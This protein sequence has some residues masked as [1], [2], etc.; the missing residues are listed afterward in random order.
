MMHCRVAC[1]T[2]P[3]RIVLWM[4]L[5]ACCAATAMASPV[6]RGKVLSDVRCYMGER[7]K[8]VKGALSI[9]Y[10]SSAACD[11]APCYY[12][13]SGV[14]GGFVIVSGNDRAER[15]L[16]YSTT[17]SFRA[18]AL[19]DNLREWLQGYCDQMCALDASDTVSPASLQHVAPTTRP[20]Q[21]MVQSHWG[22]YEPFN[23]LCPAVPSGGHALSGCVAM[24]MAMVMRYY[25]Y[26][27]ATL[28]SIPVYV[29]E[30]MG[31]SPLM[32]PSVPAGTSFDWSSMLDNYR[33]GEEAR[34]QLAV[35][36]LSRVCGLS[37][38]TNYGASLSTAEMER[39]PTAL[40]SYFGYDGG[41]LYK[42]R[43]FFSNNEWM[44][45]L[46][47]ELAAGRPVIYKGD[48][49]SASHA[50]II[51][52]C[53]GDDF[54]HVNWGFGD[55][56]DGY[57]RLDALCH[58]DEGGRAITSRGYTIDHG[59]VVGIQ[60][61]TGTASPAALP[62]SVV[63]NRVS[64][65]SVDCTFRN[66]NN[67]RRTFFCALGYADASGNLHPVSNIVYAILDAGDSLDKSFVLGSLAPGHY[68]FVPICR[69]YPGNGCWVEA[70]HRPGYVECVVDSSGCAV[71]ALKPAPE[72]M[73]EMDF[74]A[75][76]LS[77]VDQP[78]D[79]T[80]HNVGGDYSGV[81]HL[82]AST[83][84]VKGEVADK[85]GVS[86]APGKSANVRMWFTPACKGVHRV[87]LCS[88][89]LGTEVVSTAT[90]DI[91]E[92]TIVSGP[93]LDVDI[94]LDNAGLDCVYGK[95][96]SGVVRLTNPSPDIWVGAPYV[97][98]FH[99]TTSS[100]SFTGDKWFRTEVT[101]AP[102]DSVDIP[103]EHEGVMG[104]Y[105]RV[106]MRYGLGERTVKSSPT[107]Q[108]M[109]G[110]ITWQ[111]DG[112]WRA[113]PASDDIVI[114]EGVLA[115]DFTGVSGGINSVTPN[116]NPNTLYYFSEGASIPLGLDAAF[117]NV[118]VGGRAASIRLEDGHSFHAPLSFVADEIC[119]SRVPELLTDGMGYWETIALP[120][121][122]EEVTLDGS[123]M[124][125]FRSADDY[126]KDFWVRCFSAY[127][128]K[129]LL[130]G[131]PERMEANVPYLVAF[132]GNKS[133]N[134]C[135]FT[136]KTVCFRGKDAF[137]NAGVPMVCGSEY[138]SFIGTTGRLSVGPAYVLNDTGKWFEYT[139]DA[140]VAP[141]RAYVRP[142]FD[143]PPMPYSLHI[144]SEEAMGVMAVEEAGEDTAPSYDLSGRRVEGSHRG[145]VVS[146][147]RKSLGRF[148]I[149]PSTR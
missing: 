133:D 76:R 125:F 117:H 48:T 31:V 102:G 123:P 68:H 59:M 35:A 84:D 94:L 58:T 49:K 5:A 128:G 116:S 111:T 57:F 122:V 87:W 129:T 114:P 79:I 144:V 77:G 44:Q 130:F 15:V 99:N 26:P 30:S 110:F 12:V 32:Q 97:I 17:G 108:L 51:D 131:F 22:Q 109:P 96:L 47:A 45:M 69:G 140:K 50:F 56:T 52:G 135:S 138:Y 41:M 37:V 143:M 104:D 64:G 29:N 139:D 141:F 34:E 55:G 74:G 101:I 3:M 71:L 120:F 23:N 63:I 98:V 67:D 10:Q 11:G 25:E 100:G 142:K 83:T 113:A 107:L 73:A 126:G 19:P 27:S 61:A 103:F 85:V 75:P 14:D 43:T 24:A 86:L 90:V 134:Q 92:G 112:T 62:L 82:F 38:H 70:E 118:V 72:L 4:L 6:T 147:G 28:A 66:C 40:A 60:P 105:Y 95:T 91:G 78:V 46:Y 115:A 148:F 18:D 127:E 9:T 121:D 65:L 149:S 53:D 16:G 136:G 42:K 1:V 145:V 132:P 2:M 146:K 89:T 20:V 124:D 80:L 39:V 13:V 137:V 81:L 8:L 36:T 33:G 119:Y 106:A 93:L 7:G 54:F 88:D 21:P